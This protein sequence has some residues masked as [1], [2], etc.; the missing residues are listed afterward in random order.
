MVGLGMRAKI[1]GLAAAGVLALVLVAPTATAGEPAW[2]S[3]PGIYGAPANWHDIA[4]TPVADGSLAPATPPVGAVPEPGTLSLVFGGAL[5]L[6]RAARR[7][8]R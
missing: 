7:K 5:L 1:L 8:R 4:A 2:G 6:H 3:D